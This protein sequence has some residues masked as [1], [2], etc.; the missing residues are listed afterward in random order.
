LLLAVRDNAVIGWRGE[1]ERIDAMW[2]K[3]MSIPLNEPSVF[4]SLTLGKE[5]WRGSL[6]P[7]MAN[8]ELLLGLGGDRP[9]ECVILPVIV[10]SKPIAFLYGDNIGEGLGEVPWIP[11]RRLVAKAGLAFEIAILRNKVRTL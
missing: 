9:A 4:V 7:T 2:V 1:G 3:S 5:Y 11:L 8:Q 6:P 10:R